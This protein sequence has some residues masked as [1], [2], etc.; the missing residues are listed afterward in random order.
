MPCRRQ[1]EV[2]VRNMKYM[3]IH[4]LDTSSTLVGNN[5]QKTFFVGFVPEDIV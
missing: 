1:A 4:G 5:F 3:N 2:V